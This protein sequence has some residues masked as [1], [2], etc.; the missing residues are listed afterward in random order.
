M[1]IFICV[2]NNRVLLF[3]F[4]KEMISAAFHNSLFVLIILAAVDGKPIARPQSEFSS[5]ANSETLNF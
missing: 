4:T 2:Y 3:T 1:F 5:F